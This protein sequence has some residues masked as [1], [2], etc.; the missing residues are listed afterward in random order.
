LRKALEESL[1]D[2]KDKKQKLSGGTQ[3]ELEK[4]PQKKNPEEELKD[5]I[6]EEK[7]EDSSPTNFGYEDA[8]ETQNKKPP[9]LVGDKA[10]E[11]LEGGQEEREKED[12]KRKA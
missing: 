9:K 7:A 1:E 10:Q 8:K 3:E 4:Q 12:K 2:S 5:R 6:E 11:I